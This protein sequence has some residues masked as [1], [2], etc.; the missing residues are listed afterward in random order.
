MIPTLYK[1][2]HLDEFR[3]SSELTLFGFFVPFRYIYG[4]VRAIFT[5]YL[6]CLFFFF[7]TEGQGWWLSLCYL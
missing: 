3:E 1:M 4:S 6:Q 7:S 2:G 5:N